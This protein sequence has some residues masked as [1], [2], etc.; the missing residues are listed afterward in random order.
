MDGV[1]IEPLAGLG[2]EQRRILRAPGIKEPAPLLA[3]RR[4]EGV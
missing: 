3:A 2:A 4:A 1:E